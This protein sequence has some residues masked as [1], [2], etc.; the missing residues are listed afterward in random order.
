MATAT[1]G[2]LTLRAQTAADLMRASVPPVAIDAPFEEI[3]AG[4]ID[5]DATVVPVLGDLGEPVGVVSRTDLLIH[6]RESAGAGRIAPAT[7]EDLMTPTLFSVGP[8][9]PAGDVIRDMLRSKVHHLFVADDRG[10]IMG[11]ISA[12]DL[13]HHLH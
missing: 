12:C 8:D 10:A 1:D 4:L 7:A 9:T 6:I 2:R 13:P 5:H 3:L 11:L